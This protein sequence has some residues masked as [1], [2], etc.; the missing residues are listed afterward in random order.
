MQG[1][2]AWCHV[3]PG[4]PLN[5]K[6]SPRRLNV[7]HRLWAIMRGIRQPKRRLWRPSS[8]ATVIG[9]GIDRRNRLSRTRRQAVSTALVVLVLTLHLDAPIPGE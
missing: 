6:I 5:G 2:T 1:Q 9:G 7:V 4:T 3:S 8:V